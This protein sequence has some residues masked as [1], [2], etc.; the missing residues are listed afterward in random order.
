MSL[1]LPCPT[2]TVA[3]LVHLCLVVVAVATLQT[4]LCALFGIDAPIVQ[5][6]IGSWPE[7]SAAVSN[8]GGLGMLGLSW[9]DP[10]EVRRLIRETSN[11]TAAPFGINLKLDAE[12]YSWSLL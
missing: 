12:R 10:S 3:G 1:L 8:A 4:P 11:L 6:P 7:L 2:S 9:D 5:A